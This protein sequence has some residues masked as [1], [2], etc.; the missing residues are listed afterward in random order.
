M[1]R[2][3]GS[4][5]VSSAEPFMTVA[6]AT[7]TTADGNRLSFVSHCS[8]IYTLRYMRPAESCMPTAS[9]IRVG[10][11]SSQFITYSVH[12]V[13]FIINACLLGC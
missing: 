2:I 13:R 10:V 7:T 9:V 5:I 6:C 1:R 4:C 3:I 8:N 12:T 11:F